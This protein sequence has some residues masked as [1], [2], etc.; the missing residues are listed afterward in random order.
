MYRLDEDVLPILNVIH[1]VCDCG[2]SVQMEHARLEAGLTVRVFLSI[3]PSIHPIGDT[4]LPKSR[5]SGG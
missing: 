1:D 3:H 5:L 2:F 4:N